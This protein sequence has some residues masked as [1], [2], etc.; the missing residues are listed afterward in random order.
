M[1]K[2]AAV[3][4][5]REKMTTTDDAD[6]IQFTL[7]LTKRE[8]KEFLHFLV[9]REVCGDFNPDLVPYDAV[10]KKI[11]AALLPLVNRQL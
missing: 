5:S 4:R 1:R 2:Q 9:L 8:A 6:T 3:T 7:E 11:V 10:L